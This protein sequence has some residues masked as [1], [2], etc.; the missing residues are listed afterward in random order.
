MPPTNGRQNQYARRREA[1]L[2]TLPWLRNVPVGTV[3]AWYAADQLLVLDEQR[4]TVEQY[5]TRS[6]P[7]GAAAGDEEVV[8]GLRRYNVPGLDVPGAVRAIHTGLSRGAR[9]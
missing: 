5:L 7:G 3:R 4:R 2:A 1:R 6:R 9:V 8:P